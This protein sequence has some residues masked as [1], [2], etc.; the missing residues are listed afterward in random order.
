MPRRS[1]DRIAALRAE[2]M[3][4]ADA[5]ERLGFLCAKARAIESEIQ[6]ARAEVQQSEERCDEALIAL[7]GGNPDVE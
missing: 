5:R 7:G 4:L 1:K 6:Q 3:K 2:M